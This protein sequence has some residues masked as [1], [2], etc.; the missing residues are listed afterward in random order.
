LVAISEQA[1]DFEGDGILDGKDI[2]LKPLERDWHVSGNPCLSCSMSDTGQIMDVD[3]ISK[4]IHSG[5]YSFADYLRG[6]FSFI[7]HHCS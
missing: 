6:N 4:I 5:S 3:I 1:K 7:P 2:P